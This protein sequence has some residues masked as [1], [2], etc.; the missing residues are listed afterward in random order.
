MTGLFREVRQRQGVHTSRQESVLGKYSYRIDEEDGDCMQLARSQL[1]Y[2]ICSLSQR[3]TV[4]EAT[5]AEEYHYGLVLSD[6][7]C[8]ER[9]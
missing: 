2:P 8:M 7:W 1:P 9:A 6:M 5:E 3:R 4:E